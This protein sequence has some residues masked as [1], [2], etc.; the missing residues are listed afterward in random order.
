M[1]L[2]SR[3]IAWLCVLLTLWSAAAFVAHHHEDEAESARCSVCVA[4]HTASPAPEIVLP[5]ITFVA[6]SPVITAP[7]A[8][9]KQRLVVFALAVRPPP[10]L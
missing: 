2:F 8:A 5:R 1:R 7:V 6:V 10:E 9:A 4:A 3:P